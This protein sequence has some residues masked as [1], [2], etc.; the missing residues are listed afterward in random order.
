LFEN[1]KNVTNCQFDNKETTHI[2]DNGVTYNLRYYPTEDYDILPLDIE[3]SF[4]GIG[5]NEYTAIDR[6]DIVL[7]DAER[8]H[9]STEITVGVRT[10]TDIT[11]K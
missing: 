6:W 5:N 7:Y 1:W 10:I 11:V 8:K 4:Y 9:S 3:T 2:T